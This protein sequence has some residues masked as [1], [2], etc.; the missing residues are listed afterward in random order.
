MEEPVQ[1][2]SSHDALTLSVV[3]GVVRQLACR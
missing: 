3:S 2:G 1:L